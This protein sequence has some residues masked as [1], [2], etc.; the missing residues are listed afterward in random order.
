MNFVNPWKI[1][2]ALWSKLFV[3]WISSKSNIVIG[4]HSVV[5][6]G[7]N[8]AAIIKDYGTAADKAGQ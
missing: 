1:P 4:G 8:P 5:I 3:L 7:G 6:A 2:A